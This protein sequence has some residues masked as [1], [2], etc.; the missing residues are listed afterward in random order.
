M[1]TRRD[2]IKQAGLLAGGAG[3][4]QALP[5]AVQKAL[6]IDPAPGSSFADAE[7]IVLLMQ[8]NR[9]FD[10][11]FGSLQGVRGF[12]DPRAIQL[13]NKN[14]VWLQSNAAGET[15]LPFRLDIKD[16]KATWMSSLPHSWE[17][18][19]DARNEG[20]YDQ[21]LEAKRS[22]HPDYA[23]MPMT[24]GY[25][26]REDIPFYYSLADAFTVCD[27][28]FCSSLTGTTPNR[29][30]FWTGTIREKQEAA[31]HANVR[32][33]DVDYGSE[34]SWTSF[35][36]RLEELG[37]SWKIYQNEISLPMGFNEEEDAWL[38]NFTDNPLEWFTQ[39][40][41]RF[42][43]AYRAHLTRQ[44]QLLP[45]E[46]A[47][48]EKKISAATDKTTLQQ[49]LDKKKKQLL[50]AQEELARW[51]A[52][53]FEQLPQKEKNLHE[54]AFVTNR[55]DPFYHQ[56]TT[57]QYKDGDTERTMTVPKG[58]V[59][60]QFRQDVQNG[61]LPTVSW[62]VAPQNFSDHPTSPWY[63][64]WYVAEVMDILTQNPEV[65]K[66]TIFILTYDENDGCFDH[67]PPFV[68]PDPGNSATGQVSAGIDTSTDYVTLEQEWQRSSLPRKDAR[69][70]PVGLGYRVPM[71]V[72]SPWSR[73]GWV[74]S[75]V[76]D[77]TSVLQFMEKFLGH[78]T[79]KN[80]RETN[81]SS[82]RRAVCGDLTSVFRPYHGE[83]LTL[84]AFPGKEAFLESVHKAKFKQLPADYKVLTAAEITQVN[85]DPAASPLMPRQE[86]GTREAC[87]LPY[88]L[89]A[90]G[91]LD[92]ERKVFRVQFSAGK[93]VFG[94]QA[95]GSPFNVYAFTGREGKEALQN[96]HYAV[97]AGGNITSDW[98]LTSFE[99][100][101]YHIRVYGPNGFFREFA[102]NTAEP[103][104]SVHCR[105]ATV[106]GNAAQL[107]GRLELQVENHNKGQAYTIELV[108]HAY[109]HATVKKTVAPGERVSLQMDT[110]DSYGWYDCSILINGYAVFTRRYAGRIETGKASRS[111]PAMGRA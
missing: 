39:Y 95:A 54:K 82:W 25:Y 47:A 15:Y 106:K 14:L 4:W 5:A 97:T 57:L 91:E 88:E 13:P 61:Q 93:T 111:D 65:W 108:D 37:V 28:H 92:K 35:P 29:L 89:Y 109:G 43:P 79:G 56:L 8:E 81:I 85:R 75:Q 16:T 102:G 99:K 90:D 96:R 103:P 59:L 70:S 12:N 49:Q 98:S 71:I 51:T 19:V 66:K 42:S 55:Q 64:A 60:H 63:G 38:A 23:D 46:I 44:V 33:A 30:F 80:V 9:S 67:V 34:V 11:C 100:G 73:G 58:D 94:E 50:T 31:A 36:E 68:A 74:N 83:Q 105:Y 40:Q 48:L 110:A 77:H 21:W 78:K 32:N 107:S 1:G 52:E 18:Q 86:A 6:A 69:Q 41:V 27:Q 24:L 104:V 26:T 22:G 53:R 2:F 62:L 76:F 72:A 87:A 84:P 101:K 20:N 10:H 7:H 3:I 45:Q 17:N